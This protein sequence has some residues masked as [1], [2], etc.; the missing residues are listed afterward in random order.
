MRWYSYSI[1]EGYL[2]EDYVTSHHS[3]HRNA[4]ERAKDL[5]SGLPYTDIC[6][7]FSWKVELSP[8][9]QAT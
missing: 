2:K 6:R 8:R 3:V 4:V 9:K 5:F 1:V 7:V